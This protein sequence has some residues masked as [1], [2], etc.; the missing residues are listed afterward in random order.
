[1]TLETRID[2]AAATALGPLPAE[3]PPVKP[4]KTGVLLVNLG[5]PDGTD[6]WSMRRYLSEFLSDP[7]VI[8]WPR[9]IWLPILQGIVLSRRPQKS[10]KA[11][12]EIWNKEK[13][14]SP[15]RTFT[16]SQAEKLAEALAGKEVL[17]DWAMRYGRPP[18]GERLMPEATDEVIVHHS[19][20]LHIRIT[21]CT[22]DEF[23]FIFF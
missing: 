4:R 17:V 12:E 23:K 10:G 14:E 18:I 22:A 16:R 13:D 20:R 3:H 21:N 2:R 15:L 19:H 1:M 5:T 6:Y 8:E 9:A 11:Y 7:R